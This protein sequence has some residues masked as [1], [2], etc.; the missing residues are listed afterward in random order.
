MCIRDSERPLLKGAYID[1]DVF[2]GDNQ[3]EVLAKLKSKQELLGEIVTLLQSPIQNVISGLTGSSS[4][5]VAGLV[6]ALE[7]RG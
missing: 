4:Q 2:V 7:E 6:K 3:L 5:K 1:S